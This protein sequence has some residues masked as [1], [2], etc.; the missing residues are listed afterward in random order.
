MITISQFDM[1]HYRLINERRRDFLDNLFSGALAGRHYARTADLGC[2]YGFFSDFLAQRG[3][4]V[5]AYDG[6]PENVSEAARRY[7]S[8]P[9]RVWNIEDKVG[10][11]MQ[12]Y[13][14]VLCFGLLYHLENPFLAVRNLAAV[15]KETAIIETVVA[16]HPMPAAVL[17]DEP[18]RGE[19][20][21]LQYLALI[22]SESALVK[23]LAAAGFPFIYRPSPLPIHPDFVHGVSKRRTVLIATRIM[24]THS[25]LTQLVD[26]PN[27]VVSLLNHLTQKL[28]E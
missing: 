6:R 18:A 28:Q 8:I 3:N 20:Q 21:A 4:S 17:Y 26:V 13:D 23:M 9:F 14:L 25:S 12:P 19:A 16:E 11:P 1:E 7:P 2:G 10:R 5:D 24:L 22:P 15:T 27:H